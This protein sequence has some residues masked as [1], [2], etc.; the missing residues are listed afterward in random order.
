MENFYKTFVKISALRNDV[1]S[2][3][4]VYGDEEH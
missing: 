3:L 4:Y 2:L 1:L